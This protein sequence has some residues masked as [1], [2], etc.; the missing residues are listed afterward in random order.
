M[1]RQT[2]AQLIKDI[3]KELD[4]LSAEVRDLHWEV[5]HLKEKV[6]AVE[7]RVEKLGADTVSKTEFEPTK[8]LVYGLLGIVLT[9]VAVALMGQVIK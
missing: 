7:A 4:S 6:G 9:A 2:A 8:S 5:K 1:A 3:E